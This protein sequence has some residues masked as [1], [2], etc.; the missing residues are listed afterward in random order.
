M[1]VSVYPISSMSVRASSTICSNSGDQ[2]GFRKST[3]MSVDAIKDELLQRWRDEPAAKLCLN[4]VDFMAQAPHEQ[5]V[6]LTF[7]TLSHAAGKK[8]VDSE[9]LTAI[10]ILASS[11]IAVLDPKALFIDDDETEYEISTE[12]LADAQESG[13]LV[14]PYTGETLTN[15]ESKIMPFFVPSER[16]L[17]ELR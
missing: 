4:I 17:S 10:T 16:F 9:L 2:G 7:G 13:A 5:L 3:Q 6:M 8:S 11:K 15:F 12:E 1:V 14:H